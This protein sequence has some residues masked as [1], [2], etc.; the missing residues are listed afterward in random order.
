MDLGHRPSRRRFVG[1]LAAGAV[2]FPVLGPARGAGPARSANG[3]INLGFIGVGTMGRG[4]LG[5]FLNDP[6]VQ[7]VA[8]CDVVAARREA[9]RKSADDRYAEQRKKGTY[10]GCQAY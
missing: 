10:R 8:V 9:A 4:H 6:G 1:T 7:V 3:R 2:T 5:G